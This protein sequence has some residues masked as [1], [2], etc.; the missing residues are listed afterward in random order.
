MAI[1]AARFHIAGGQVLD[2]DRDWDE[3]ERGGDPCPVRPNEPA[4][5]QLLRRVVCDA[6]AED[7][8]QVVITPHHDRAHQDHVH[9]ELVPDVD[10]SYVH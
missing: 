3:R 10:W 1:D 9:L 5:S 6:V 2:V 8:F 4:S 7:L